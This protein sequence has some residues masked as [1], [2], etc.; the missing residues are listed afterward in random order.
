MKIGVDAGMLG[1]TDERLQVGVWRVA[2][3][4]LTQL[5]KIDQVN[6]Y[7]LYSFHPIPKQVMKLFGTS[8]VNC[9]L[10]P[11]LGWMQIRL[12]L[13]LMMHPVDVFLGLSQ[14]LPRTHA[15]T[16]GFVYDLGFITNPELYPDSKGKLK[17]QTNDLAN[18][19]D[20]LVTISTSM[21]REIVNQ[22]AYPESRIHI[23]YPSIAQA[24]TLTGV[25]YMH[26]RPYFLCVGSFKRGKNIPTLI[27]AFSRYLISVGKP[28]DLLLVGSSYW[29]D[30]EI[31]ETI[32]S[33]HV[34]DHV[35]I[36]GYIKDDELATLYRGAIAFV[37][38]SFIEGFGI[39]FIEAMASGIPVIGSSIP[40]LV[41]VVG[42]AGI[43]V[44]PNNVDEL[45]L[46]MEK[47]TNG[48][49]LRE[50]LVKNG[51]KRVKSYSGSDMVKTVLSLL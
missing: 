49:T 47:I 5:G 50:K 2:K 31:V 20:A 6:S 3:E 38:P 9:V 43:F 4:L 45:S 11:S 32:L 7:I 26:P 27:R 1:I 25:R 10:S 36:K 48:K 35:I 28:V 42:D 44:D 29:Q 15:K 19:A 24:F 23:A 18:S 33:E 37:C 40:T 14:A 34:G 21:K 12:P 30:P 39:P 17:R 8:M 13:E 46:A 16:I 22:Y 41:E 51:K